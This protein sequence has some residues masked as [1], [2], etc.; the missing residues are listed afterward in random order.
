MSDYRKTL[1]LLSSRFEMRGDLAKREPVFLD[2]WAKTKTYRR[3]RRSLRGRQR[4]VLHD[5]PP[6]ANGSLHVG[7]ALNKILKDIIVRSKNLAGFDAPYVPGWDCHG[8][9]IEHQVEKIIKGD[10]DAIKSCPEIRKRV[11]LYLKDGELSPN[12]IRNLCK[13]YAQ[14]QIENQLRDFQRLGV[15]GDWERPYKTIDPM[16]EA[17]EIRALAEIYKSGVLQLGQKPVYWCFDCQS[18]LAEAEI[19]YKDKGSDSIDVAFKSDEDSDVYKRF[20]VESEKPVFVVIWTTTP[21]TIP[22]NQCLAAHPDLEYLL[23]DVGDRL[24]ILA[25]KLAESSLSRFNLKGRSVAMVKGEKLLGLRFFHPFEERLSEILISDFVD[26]STGTGIVHCA[27]AHGLDDYSLY[28]KKNPD[29]LNLVNGKGFYENVPDLEGMHVF[30]KGT[31]RKILEKIGPSLISS[32]EIV[33]SYPH[34]WRHK[35]P[36]I[37]RA[38]EQWFISMDKNLSNGDLRSKALDALD[39]TKFFPSWGKSRIYNMIAN[40]P[41]WCISRERVWGVPLCIFISKHDRTPHPRSL[42]IFEKVALKVEKGG[43]NAWFEAS[44]SEFLEETE[45]KDYQR[46]NDILDVWFDSGTTHFHVVRGSHNEDLNFPVDLYLEGSDQHRGWFHSSLLT[47]CL[48]DG[49]APYNQILTHGFTVD[50][51]GHKMSKSL[52]N[53]IIPQEISSTLGADILRLW[54]GST[55]Y[56]GEL[57]ISKQILKSVTDSYRRIRNTL[58]FLISN[59]A[60]FNFLEDSVPVEDLVDLD[61]YMLVA[62]SRLQEELTNKLYPN[63]HFHLITQRLLYFCAEDLSAF[64]LDILKDRLYV[65]AANDPM[66]RSAQTV[67]WHIANSLILML[68]P[69]LSFTA[70]E[71]WEILQNDENSWT[72]EQRWH[73]FPDKER[74]DTENLLSRW[75]EIRRIRSLVNKTIE[76]KRTSS[77]IASS[78]EAEVHIH[79]DPCTLEILSTQGEYLKSVF[80]VSEVR[81]FASTEIKVEVRKMLGSKCERCWHHFSGS[82]EICVRCSKI[83]GV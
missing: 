51:N 40:R 57:R 74:L 17:G 53:V 6:Y 28:T 49:R 22:S 47:G 67:L 3:L 19:E 2:R 66:R 34:C 41:D 48:I 36:V 7:H 8:L 29:I 31:T 81:L 72:Q 59:L 42:E 30:D 82:G 69:I 5:G 13:E 24:L 33:H 4:F 21:W 55:D 78:L 16:S 70:E 64:Y 76:E 12:K 60:D 54:V 71:A 10:K 1:N 73:T 44:D 63:Y 75:S 15:I 77:E 79:G 9:P 45:L 83:L 25:K 32:K 23:M 11:E 35:T 39:S 52:G 58:R 26:E 65:L 37:F 14:I 56:S 43:I 20:S 46:V 62:T 38:T 50:G 61:K 27:P 18:A 80:I 68:S